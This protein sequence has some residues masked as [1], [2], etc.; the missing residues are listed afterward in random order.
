MKKGFYI[1][2]AL[3]VLAAGAAYAGVFSDSWRYKM[4][5][6]VET[7]EGIK[8]GS[9]V[10]E[11]T[12]KRGIALT[13][14][15]TA[16]IEVKGEAVAIDLEKRGVLFMISN[17]DYAG[18]ILF[19]MFPGKDKKGKVVLPPELYAPFVRFRDLGDPKTIENIRASNEM[20]DAKK[21]HPRRPLI[22]FEDA[23]GMGVSVKE[24]T[25][26]ITSEPITWGIEKYLPWV[27]T[28]G[29]G[30]LGGGKFSGPEW[31]EQLNKWDFKKE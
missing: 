23:F 28:V 30:N 6:T 15:M 21:Q 4:T 9:A 14:Q 3:L 26:E 24:V 11:V 7:P 10:R 12:V 5:V 22:A 1:V 29:S 2:A 8:I 31:Y 25:M 18:N 20:E 27:L 16:D 17:G 13:P 19:K